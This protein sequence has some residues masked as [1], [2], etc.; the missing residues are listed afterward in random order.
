[1]NRQSARMEK[2]YVAQNPVDSAPSCDVEYAHD[3]AI[4][5]RHQEQ[6]MTTL[7]L[8]SLNKKG[9]QALYT[10]AR[11][12]IR[13]SVK[14]FVD[15]TPPTTL[16]LDVLPAVVRTAK[17]KL[18]KEER[19]LLPKPTLAERVARAEKRAASLKAKLAA[20]TSQSA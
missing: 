5:L 14:N 7:T 20:E 1:M 17:V 11:I 10:G 13:I 16:D 3:A 19:A 8:K 18:T 2:E 12:V 15:A 9:T 4:P 6:I